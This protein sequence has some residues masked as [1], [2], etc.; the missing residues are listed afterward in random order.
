[1]VLEIRGVLYT[2]SAHALLKMEERN[3][4]ESW[5]KAAV[6]NP[7]VE[8]EYDESQDNYRYEKNVPAQ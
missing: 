4:P 5:V 7:D 3:I 1:M 2:L 8:P 6:L